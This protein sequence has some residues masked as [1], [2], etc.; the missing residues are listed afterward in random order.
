MQHF[1]T[2]ARHTIPKQL[3]DWLLRPVTVK[4]ILAAEDDGVDLALQADELTFHIAIKTSDTF[5]NIQRAADQL[6]TGADADAIAILVVPYMGPKARELARNHSLS[7]F[8]LSGNADVTGPGLRI[9]IEGQPNR[10]AAPGRPSSA[11][12]PKAARLS[13]AMLTEP[14]R[15]W[16][17]RELAEATGLSVGYVSK[18][19]ARLVEDEQLDR[20][21]GDGLLRP[22]AP[23]QLLDAWAQ[24]YDF[25]KHD[26]M[27]FHTVGRSGPEILAGLAGRLRDTS[28]H[29][30]ATGLAAAWQWSKYA[31]FR[32]TTVFVSSPIV[33]AEALRLRPVEQGENVWIVVPNDDGVFYA[34]Q[35][36]DG[37]TCVHPVQAYLDLL[38]H[39]E[40]AQEAATHLRSQHLNWSR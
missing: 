24:I 26:V 39:P 6:Q 34:A 1:E 25:A 18:V 29:W 3:Q 38:G 20:R 7:W 19:A 23:A 35:D 17:Q 2:V 28:G 16:L 13:R 8:D 11:F 5:T 32:L 4:T 33:D 30:A 12:S 9:L 22:R 27:R 21:T 31:D 14:E 10:F 15:W 40:R 37:V 36:V